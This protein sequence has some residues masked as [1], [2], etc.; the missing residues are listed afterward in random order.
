MKKQIFLIAALC[1]S[2]WAMADVTFEKSGDFGWVNPGAIV[3]I[4][5]NNTGYPS[6]L[7][8]ENASDSRAVYLENNAGTLTKHEY[9]ANAGL[10]DLGIEYY[11]SP[12]MVVMDVNKDGKQD[13]VVAG[14]WPTTIAVYLNNG[15]GGL[16]FDPLQVN[17]GG[18]RDYDNSDFLAAGDYDNDG[19]VDL[20]VLGSENAN[21]SIYR[22]V[23]GIFAAPSQTLPGGRGGS[24]AVGD[25]NGDGNLDIFYSGYSSDYA[26]YLYYGNGA[27][28]WTAATGITFDKAIKGDLAII[29]FNND[30]KMDLI[31]QGREPIAT[32]IYKNNG[33]GTFTKYDKDA[34]GL[35]ATND[36]R[37]AYGDFNLD[38][39]M[40]IIASAWQVGASGEGTAIFLNNG[41]FTFTK[42]AVTNE[43]RGGGIFAW[44]YD[45]DK[46]CDYMVWNYSDVSAWNAP[47]A[48]NTTSPAT[49]IENAT[50]QHNAVKV[51]KNGQL[52]II[53]DG[54]VFNVLGT[55]L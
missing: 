21:L 9:G 47:I 40:D 6:V 4:D 39:K 53:R 55:S 8:L 33:D 24:I 13:L 34:N 52:M 7:Y 44:D 49:A 19:W 46:K 14:N 42:T 31:E 3:A 1:V 2:A 22:N 36:L 17:L 48:H 5:I 37:S 23:N 30:G 32:N 43:A 10:T 38:G 25:I 16:T 11:S 50:E 12:G 18:A 27:G 51:I 35:P 41:N 45:N 15:A 54:K 20:F 28:V 29:D 26:T